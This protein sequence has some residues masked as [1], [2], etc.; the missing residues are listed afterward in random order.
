[1][2]LCTR[3]TGAVGEVGPGGREELGWIL[4]IDERAFFRLLSSGV[5][6]AGGGGGGTCTIM[7]HS[8]SSVGLE[9]TYQIQSNLEKPLSCDL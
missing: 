9:A 8:F 6:P 3:S 7:C 5:S 2:G 1:M 4:A